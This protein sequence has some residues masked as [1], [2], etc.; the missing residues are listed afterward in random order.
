MET[1]NRNID[2]TK[3]LKKFAT[4]VW[5]IGTYLGLIAGALWFAVSTSGNRPWEI[6]V[7][8]FVV[9]MLVNWLIF[10]A[11]VKVANDE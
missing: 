2:W 6:A 10:L 5:G 8:S 3:S 11:F 9:T 1:Q 7:T 4:V